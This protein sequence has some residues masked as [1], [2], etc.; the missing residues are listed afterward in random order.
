MFV[1]EF[2]LAG[3]DVV[4]YLDVVIDGYWP[5]PTVLSL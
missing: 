5:A 3:V 1:G 2:V 4:L